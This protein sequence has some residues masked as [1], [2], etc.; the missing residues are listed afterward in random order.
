MLFRSANGAVVGDRFIGDFT[1]QTPDG[2][3]PIFRAGVAVD[4]AQRP[5]DVGGRVALENVACAGS[6]IEGW[7]PARDSTG[8]GASALS[9]FLAGERAA[10]WV[11][12]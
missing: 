12:S 8:A 5:L 3:H 1:A 4:D 6:I 2:D 9:G 10:S 7:D 11:T